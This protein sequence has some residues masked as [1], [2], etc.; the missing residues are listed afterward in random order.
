M[1]EQEKQALIERCSNTIYS[2][3]VREETKQIFR[4]ALASLT[5][6]PVKLPDACGYEHPEK[7]EPFYTLNK[8]EVIAAIRASGYEVEE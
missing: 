3:G 8:D 6:P 7:E 4:I 2:A 5:A 1:T